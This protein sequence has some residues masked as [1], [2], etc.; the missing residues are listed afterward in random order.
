MS[1]ITR[2]RDR[3]SWGVESVDNV[4]TRARLHPTTDIG[5]RVSLGH[6]VHVREWWRGEVSFPMTST[7][8]GERLAVGADKAVNLSRADA[9]SAERSYSR[10]VPQ[11]RV[12]GSAVRQ[13]ST[14]GF[15]I[16][17]TRGGLFQIPWKG[18][19]S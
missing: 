10:S 14:A 3:R 15:R 1:Q 16:R 7:S 9:N 13:G 19:T 6:A 12:R 11:S 18:Y 4:N 2:D 17:T 8:S 5:H